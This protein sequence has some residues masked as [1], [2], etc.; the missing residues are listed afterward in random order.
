MILSTHGGIPS[1]LED[2]FVPRNLR[3]LQTYILIEEDFEYFERN[4]SY[5]GQSGVEWIIKSG[6]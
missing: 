6:S 3:A 4:R 1:G 5:S 2:L